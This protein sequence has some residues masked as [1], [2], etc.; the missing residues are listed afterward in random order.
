M[1]E[2]KDLIVSQ[3]SDVSSQI[4]SCSTL[5]Y[6]GR[7]IVNSVNTLRSDILQVADLVSSFF[8][9]AN[10]NLA[11]VQDRIEGPESNQRKYAGAAFWTMVA[12]NTVMLILVGCMIAQT[13]VLAKWKPTT[14]GCCKDG[15]DE[16]E[17]R[18]PRVPEG[19]GNDACCSCCHPGPIEDDDG[20]ASASEGGCCDADCIRTSTNTL[21]L[22]LF[23]IFLLLSWLFASVTLIA[24]IAGA[25]FCE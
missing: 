25:D 12:V 21:L 9:A 7:S 4:Q 20:E 23:V 13:F 17:D 15:I 6:D 2:Q 24:S 8:E 10:D 19:E 14:S 5:T 11:L 3:V 18:V 22:P 1:L 16:E